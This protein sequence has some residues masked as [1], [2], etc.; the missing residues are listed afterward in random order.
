M[1]SVGM[2]GKIWPGA[3]FAMTFALQG[4]WSTLATGRDSGQWETSDPAIRNWYQSLMQPDAP[5]MPCCGEADAYWA[6]EVHVRDGKV[7]A[8]IT[9]ER[10][11]APLR[12]PHIPPGT[13]FEIPHEKLKWDR[14]NPT[15]HNVLFV[16]AGNGRVFCFVQNGGI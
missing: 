7:F 9:D 12:R 1:I 11:D 4:A 8:K 16:G 2:R 3:A 14:G 15:G 6:D 5:A 10:D 13:E